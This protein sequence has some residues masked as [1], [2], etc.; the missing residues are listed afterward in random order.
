MPVR[1]QMTRVKRINERIISELKDLISQSIP[2]NIDNQ[3]RS[4]TGLPELR[5][6]VSGHFFFTT[7]CQVRGDKE[8]KKQLYDAVRDEFV[9]AHAHYRPGLRP[10][11]WWKWDAP[12]LRRVVGRDLDE[13]DE[14]DRFDNRLPAAEDPNLPEWAKGKTYFGKP[15]VYEGM[16]T[17]MNAVTCND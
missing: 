5:G 4:C 6:L 3:F 1:K 11:A 9:P 15:S 2:W 14:P 16:F 8:T 17:R 12:E 7:L 13:D 10:W